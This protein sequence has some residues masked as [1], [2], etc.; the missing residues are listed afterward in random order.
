M[1]NMSNAEHEILTIED[2]ALLQ[3]LQY[4]KGNTKEDSHN[5]VL[6]LKNVLFLSENSNNSIILKRVINEQN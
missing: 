3:S 2:P 5:T 4:S 1:L 6:A